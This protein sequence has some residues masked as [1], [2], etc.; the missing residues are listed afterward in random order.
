MTN[1]SWQQWQ[2]A[3]HSTQAEALIRGPCPG[4]RDRVEPTGET[5]RAKEETDMRRVLAS[6]A[7]VA[8]GVAVLLPTAAAAPPITP[9]QSAQPSY[10][11]DFLD[12][13]HSYSGRLRQVTIC[14]A[15]SDIWMR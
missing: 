14:A 3:R 12:H 13:E 11:L 2:I 1:A 8:L 4:R 5:D 9:S 10:V 6:L 7:A 15:L